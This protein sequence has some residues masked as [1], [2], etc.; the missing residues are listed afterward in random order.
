MIPEILPVPERLRPYIYSFWYVKQESIP[1]EN[2]FI[3][4]ADGSTGLIFQD[5]AAGTMRVG[6]RRLAP[7]YI[8]GQASTWSA[9]SVDG[10]FDAIG[11]CFHPA[12]FRKF[13]KIP[14]DNLTDTCLD[15]SEIHSSAHRD[16][17][18]RLIDGNNLKERAGM[19]ITYLDACLAT[20]MI[21][22][23]LVT[24]IAVS[25]IISSAGNLSLPDL[26]KRL[27]ISERSLERRFKENVGIS[28]RLFA[29]ICRF[30]DAIRQVR[31]QNFEK[32]SD[33]AY[34][35][36][37]ADQSHFIRSFRSFA[38]CSPNQYI[39]QTVR[40]LDSFKQDSGN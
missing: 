3:T 16:I 6:N 37:Y 9:L 27:H 14:A 17:S 4:M 20:N 36:G 12:A 39:N 22:Q 30:Q 13:F 25:S 23:D 19:L 11:V 34:Q 2:T 10:H 8:Y 21:K 32:L 33:I 26:Q 1:T 40:V 15:V 24:D 7:L 18:V 31:G 5:P 35:N 29:R 38:G 28:A